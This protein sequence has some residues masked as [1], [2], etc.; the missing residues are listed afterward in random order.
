VIHAATRFYGARLKEARLARALTATALAERAD[1]S[2]PSISQYESQGRQPR[3]PVVSA[4]AQ[5]LGVPE[6]FFFRPPLPESASPRRFR[7]LAATTKMARLSV[8]QRLRWLQEVI[9][10]LEQYVDLPQVS[11]PDVGSPAQPEELDMREIEEIAAQVRCAWGL[12]VG[13]AP[14][15]VGLIE[16]RGI[17]VARFSFQAREIDGVSTFQGGRPLIALNTEAASAVRSRFD[18]AHELGHLIM[19]KQAPANPPADLH[20]VLERQAHR[21]AGAFLLPA[22][23]FCSELYSLHPEALLALKARW[24]CSMS[25]MIRRAFDLQVITEDQY[26]RASRQLSAKGYRRVE[27]LDDE[28]EPEQPTML[29][30]AVKLLVEHGVQSIPEIT[31]SLGFSLSDLRMLVNSPPGLFTPEPE[32]EPEP[33]LLEARVVPFRPRQ[34]P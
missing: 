24:R 5:A 7:S 33:V 11:V 27:P 29:A 31:H 22:A 14:N 21:F 32:A 28:L 16:S 6:S 8:E 20:K 17:C 13:P 23:T 4:L 18:V 3:P 34:S 12:G 25:L 10:Y 19:H 26:S 9:G 1:I 30:K 2:I 15:L